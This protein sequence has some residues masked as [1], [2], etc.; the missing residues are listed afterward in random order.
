LPEISGTKPENDKTNFSS[1]NTNMHGRGQM[2]RK[3]VAGNINVHVKVSWVVM[4][5]DVNSMVL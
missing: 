2:T 5:E 3:A 4:P 1:S